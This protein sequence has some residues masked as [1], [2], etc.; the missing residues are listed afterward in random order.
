MPRR[1]SLNGLPEEIRREVDRRLKE[2]SFSGYQQIADYLNELGYSTSK[3]SVHRYG[4]QFEERLGALQIANEQAKAI[5]EAA[6]ADGENMM[7]EALL[8]LTQEKAFQVLL[9]LEI[10]G[11]NFDSK[12]FGRLASAV[13]SLGRANVYVS[14]YRDEYR[15]KIAERFDQL[16]KESKTSGS[17]DPA[18][19]QRIR[20]EIYGLE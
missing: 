16:E 7:S 12:S 20:E 8:R 19:L 13:A 5:A 17:L 2:G 11:E 6:S 9:N 3:S 10:Q 4:Q 18:T 15:Q 1:S 14:R